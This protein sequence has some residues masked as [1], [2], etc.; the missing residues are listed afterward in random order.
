ML[1]SWVPVIN[2]LAAMIIITPYRRKIAR[3]WLLSK[4]S[5]FSSIGTVSQ[6]AAAAGTTSRNERSIN[7]NLSS[8][9]YSVGAI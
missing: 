6:P 2:P 3:M 8:N 1:L 9:P 7:E 5:E 4:G